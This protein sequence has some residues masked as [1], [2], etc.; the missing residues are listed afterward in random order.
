MGRI[1]S[2]VLEVTSP[3]SV[4]A[5]RSCREA[6]L[7]FPCSLAFLNFSWGVLSDTRS[8]TAILSTCR[9][10]SPSSQHEPHEP[11]DDYPPPPSAYRLPFCHPFKRHFPVDFSP[12]NGRR[13]PFPSLA[14][15]SQVY[16]GSLRHEGNSLKFPFSPS[17]SPTVQGVFALVRPRPFYA[18]R[19]LPLFCEVQVSR[20]RLLPAPEQF[21]TTLSD[22]RSF[23]P[24]Q[25]LLLFCPFFSTQMM[26]GGQASLWSPSRLKEALRNISPP[27]V[28]FLS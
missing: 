28:F 1:S 5:P 3:F 7:S 8:L 27:P 21:A 9:T 25:S 4:S 6:I 22:P 11:C 15:H 12:L 19:L 18:E 2:S 24:A 14:A 10:G 13:C 16:F 20:S 17:I 26:S 23:F